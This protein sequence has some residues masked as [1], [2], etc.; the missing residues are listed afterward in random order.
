[1]PEMLYTVKEVS[2]SGRKSL[3]DSSLKLKVM[4]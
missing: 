3:R 1:M 4:I 2:R